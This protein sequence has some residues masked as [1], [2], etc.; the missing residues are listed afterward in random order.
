MEALFVALALVLAP[1]GAGAA[2]GRALRPRA[3]VGAVAL[4]ALVAVALAWAAIPAVPELS[5]YD[6]LMAAALFG[7][8]M[9]LAARR[10]PL[11][12]PRP[13]LIGTGLFAVVALAGLELRARALPPPPMTIP[14]PDQQSFLTPRDAREY[15]AR[16]V[17]PDAY[18]DQWLPG[19]RQASDLAHPASGRRVLHLGDS[20]VA[21]G[22]VP[23]GMG[24]AD[25]MTREARGDGDHVNMGVSNSGTD[26]HLAV[27]R[28]WLRRAHGD[29]VVLHLFSGND[30]EEMDR[31][32]AYCASGPL[33]GPRARGMPLLCP[34]PRWDLSRRALL[35]EGPSPYPLRLLA[36]YSGLARQLTWGFELAMRSMR[37]HV[38][39]IDDAA[40]QWARLS[41]AVATLRDEAAREGVPLVVSVLPFHGA[42]VGAP[43]VERDRSRARAARLV[44][45][46]RALGVRTLDPLPDLAAAV[47]ARPDARW[48]LPP[49]PHFDVDG[50]RW[51][52]RWLA[53]KLAER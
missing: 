6:L 12:T 19:L 18:F 17:F 50:H 5:P 38:A 13:V 8:A 33:L 1:V 51:Y 24:F 52:A 41:D 7:A 27:F 10:G 22:D 30:P 47:Q 36:W 16:A 25:V 39:Y 9:V 14:A 11:K 53:A 40:P 43:D 4:G 2:L 29:A 28:R 32:Y 42:V 34:S 15:G 35:A 20:M 46:C 45:A 26:L 31:P 3:R 48:F 44:A 49:S 23:P 37:T 21:A